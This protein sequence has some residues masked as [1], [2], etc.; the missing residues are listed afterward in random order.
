MNLEQFKKSITQGI[1]SILPPSKTPS[2]RV[3]HAPVRKE[4]L[5][6][7][8]KEL[9]LANA[10]RYFP[11]DQH[12]VLAPEFAQELKNYGRIYMYR[13]MP[14]VEI[15]ARPVST[16]MSASCVNHVNDSEQPRCCCGTASARANYL[17]WK[18]LGI[19]KLGSV[20]AY[21]EV[22]KRD[23]FIPNPYYFFRPSN[24][25]FPITPRRP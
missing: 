8:E 18:R 19:P 3:S 14:D 12:A 10:L 13:L 17:W 2:D 9:A 24:G 20:Q 5:T 4:I 7:V 1:P 22:F 16:K 6:S 23:G 21:D 15:K 25:T 11:E